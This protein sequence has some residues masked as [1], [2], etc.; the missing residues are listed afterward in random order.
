MQSSS[1]PKKVDLRKLCVTAVLATL[2]YVSL[3]FR[4][5][6]V[7]FLSYE[8]KDV[9]IALGGFLFGPLT[10]VVMSVLVSLL[11]MVTISSTG[12]IG[13]VMNILGTCA[14]ACTASVIYQKKRS[15]SG[16]VIALVSAC[17]V[18][19][20]TMLLWNYFIT[21]FYMCPP[22]MTVG[23]MRGQVAGMLI[24]IFL[25]FNLLKSGLNSAL[26]LLL[27]KPL[28]TALRRA[29][30]LTGSSEGEKGKVNLWMIL[31]SLLL[32]CVLILGF[33]K[34]SGAI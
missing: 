21:P 3:L 13:C 10:S 33:L 24:P 34:L 29:K 12:I 31:V 1:Q 23:Q 6:I 17:L 4:I 30:V 15:L 8:P 11:E 28:V 25:P 26:L 19:T 7:L 20:A 16:A 22:D 2:A 18:M 32:L 9:L 5:P 14:F 27:Y